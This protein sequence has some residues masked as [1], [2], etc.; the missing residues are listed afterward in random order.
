S[1]THLLNS[2]PDTVKRIAVLDRTKEKGAD[3]QPL[4]L[5]V[6]NVFYEKENFD[7]IIGSRT[8]CV[9]CHFTCVCSGHIGSCICKQRGGSKWCCS[10]R[11]CK[12]G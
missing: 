12:I 4:Y 5:D 11:R 3:G 9:Q 1:A 6:R 8:N 7:G 2:I 10:F